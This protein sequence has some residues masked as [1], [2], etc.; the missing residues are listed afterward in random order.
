MEWWIQNWNI[1]L[2]LPLIYGIY[3]E[4]VMQEYNSER[5]QLFVNYGLVLVKIYEKMNA[6]K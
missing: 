6:A 3:I 1:W 2:K 4:E 5:L